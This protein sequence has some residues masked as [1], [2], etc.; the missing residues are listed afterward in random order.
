[1]VI[2]QVYTSHGPTV[3]MPTWCCMRQV[4]DRVGGFDEGGKVHG[5]QELLSLFPP[6]PLLN[7][8]TCMRCTFH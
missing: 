5:L 1:M 8:P 6:P 4:F 3:I 2:M 7:V